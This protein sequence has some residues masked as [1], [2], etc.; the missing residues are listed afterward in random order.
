MSVVP[1]HTYGQNIHIFKSF[2]KLKKTK[3]ASLVIGYTAN[4]VFSMHDGLGSMPA[5]TKIKNYPPI[6]SC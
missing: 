5:A 1:K 6:N 3:K 4:H 2:K